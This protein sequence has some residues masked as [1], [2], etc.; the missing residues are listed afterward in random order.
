MSNIDPPDFPLKLLKWFCK[1]AYHRDIEGDLLELFDRRIENVGLRKAK[2]LLFKDVVLLFRPGIIRSFNIKFSFM[3]KENLKIASRQM[4]KQKGLTGIKI[5]GLALG[6]AACLLIILFIKDELSYDRHY[7]DVERIYR[8]YAEYHFDGTA[9][10]GAS[11]SPPLTTAILDEFPEVEAAARINS[12]VTLDGPGSNQFRRADQQ[13]NTYEE[14]FAYADQSILDIFQFPMLYGDAV[15]A[16]SAPNTIVIT[17]E[18]ANKYFPNEN[19]LGKTIILND[20]IDRPF[21]ITGVLARVPTNS[22]LQFDF[23]L[24]LAGHEFWPEEQNNWTVNLYDCYLKLKPNIDAA[25]FEQKLEHISRNYLGPAEVGKGFYESIEAFLAAFQLRLQPVN[26]VYLL[27]AADNI[28]DNY[29]HG[30]IRLVWLFGMIALFV[31][32][33]AGVNFINLSTAK[34]ANR[35]KE[36]G[37]RKVLGSARRALVNQFLTESFLYTLFALISGVGIAYW[38]LPLFNQMAAKSMIL[39][40]KELWFL[41]TLFA[42]AILIGVLAGLYP[43][44]LSLRI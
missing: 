23:Y 33:L 32:L 16:L 5:G 6:I 15:T 39:P 37:V 19:P 35:A 26:E 24:S 13:Q 27:S 36:V 40:W 31:L 2:W 29:E 4:A 28:F 21:E 11:L 14:G 42:A 12:F 1:P 7:P 41:P 18:K 38:F 8:I 3:L 10:G 22:H 9:S 34:S 17:E 20:N 43:R 25:A 30:D 44:F